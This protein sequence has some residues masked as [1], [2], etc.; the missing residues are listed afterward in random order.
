MRWSYFFKHWITTV[1]IGSLI[2]IFL[3]N[4][5]VPFF[6]T[7]IEWFL[8]LILF[9]AV[10]SFPT[11]IVLAF[12]FNYLENFEIEIKKVKVIQ[13]LSTI[14][15]VV[16]SELVIVQNITL[17]TTLGYSLPAVISGMFFKLKKKE[18]ENIS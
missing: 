7:S 11:F 1:L 10:F 2:Y 8:I 13:I 6:S 17:E 14:S 4:I 12:V 18:T 16:L 3:N 5:T 9:S 15:G